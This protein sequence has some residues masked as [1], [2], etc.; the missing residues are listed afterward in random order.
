MTY[1]CMLKKDFSGI[2]EVRS[3]EQID[4]EKRMNAESLCP[5]TTVTYSDSKVNCQ[6]RRCFRNLVV[7]FKKVLSVLFKDAWT[8]RVGY[9]GPADISDQPASEV[10]LL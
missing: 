4:K 3:T 1:I 6:K 8:A 9:C 7:V 5:K 2:S 10:D